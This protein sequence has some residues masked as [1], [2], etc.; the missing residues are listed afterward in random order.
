MPPED[1]SGPDQRGWSV[2]PALPRRQP[3]A[4][5]LSAFS[6]APAGRC[7]PTR[8]GRPFRLVR[9]HRDRLSALVL[10]AVL[11]LRVT[12]AGRG[13]V[14]LAAASD[15]FGPGTGLLCARILAWSRRG[16]GSGA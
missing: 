15:T 9:A 8:Q 3:G 6:F 4:S 12:L 16:W 10:T 2:P 11:V 13:A 1:R 5:D 7:E 14:T